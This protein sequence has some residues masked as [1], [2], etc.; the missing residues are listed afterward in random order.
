[1][2][3][4][5]RI[6]WALP[7]GLMVIALLLGVARRADAQSSVRYEISKTALDTTLL[8]PGKPAMAAVVFELKSGFH[9]QSR[10]PNDE[11]LVRFD[12]KV[13]ESPGL[14]TGEAIY[15]AGE[16]K[17]YPA[18]GKLS[19]YEKQ[20]IIRFPVQVA[21]NA[22]PG[23]VT[24]KGTLSF[25][26]CDD[27]TCFPPE[28]AAFEIKATIGA[29]DATPA[30][31]N[32]DLF[33]A[34]A[35]VASADET[36]PPP[37]GSADNPLAGYSVPAVFG[38]AF[39][40]GI[41][42]NIVPCV[43]PV[44]PIKAIG[45]YETAQHNRLKSL[46]F[47]AAFSVGVVAA[48]AVLGLLVVVFKTVTWGQIFS[49]PWFSLTLVVIL[50]AMA[51]NMFGF[52]TINLPTGAYAFSPRHDTYFGN[53]LFGIL[54]AALSTPCT[55]GLFVGVL[56]VALQ[57]S[58]FVGL[59]MVC[60]V[61]AGMAS[62]YLV[63]SAMPELA[64]RFP[65]T[66]PWAELVKQSM[67]FLLLAVAVFFA[68]GHLERFM[69]A[70]GVWWLIFAIV[71]AGGIFVIIR[72]FQYGKTRVAPIV[73]VT[74]AVLLVA[75]AFYGARLLAVK[76]YEWQPYTS[77][78]LQRAKDA[79]QVVLV[80]FTASWCSNCHALEAIVLNSRQIQRTVEDHKVHMVKADLSADDAPGWKLFREELKAEG[81]PLTV[82]YSPHLSAPTRL[83]G[84]YSKG[85]LQAAIEQ[86][87]R[88]Q[89]AMK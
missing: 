23:D 56:A 77:E 38:I 85:D 79:G 33:A 41:I 64:R 34:A 47:G 59:L 36:A 40:V 15:P 83:A 62:P 21:A 19:V 39:L 4:A 80:E 71:A 30:P 68:K 44:L 14:T 49:N 24:I 6:R 63:L 73:G 26:I 17:E 48:F 27:K 58:P 61:G 28:D 55:F 46:S 76:P 70:P 43:L 5:Q 57:Q 11:N 67:G 60:T 53:F 69:S 7:L 8:V 10:T 89:T 72:C 22:Q 51:A 3:T 86:A 65:R 32:Q 12:A 88:P 20:A 45:F 66:G 54:T 74:I 31:A 29:A 37:P 81:V 25:Q 50:V 1:M 13:E 2:P 82:I 52:F 84:F 16:I 18:L 35:A 78:N 87:S 75:P 9:A 42:F